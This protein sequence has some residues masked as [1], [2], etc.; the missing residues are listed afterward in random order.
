M[1]DF[2]MSG[3]RISFGGYCLRCGGVRQVLW[4]TRD[5]KQ[6]GHELR[7]GLSKRAIDLF[8]WFRVGCARGRGEKLNCSWRYSR[9]NL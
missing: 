5:V 9:C 3:F 4:C 1:Y 8:G 7:I 6:A 2:E